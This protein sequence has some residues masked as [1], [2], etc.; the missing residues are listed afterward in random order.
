MTEEKSLLEQFHNACISGDIDVVKSLPLDKAQRNAKASGGLQAIHYASM[1]G[2][3][4]VAQYLIKEGAQ[5]NARDDNGMSPLHHACRN[6][7]IV[8]VR[9][10]M[11]QK[12][13]KNNKNNEGMSPLLCAAAAGHLEIVKLLF[14]EKVFDFIVDNDGNSALHL[15][16]LNRQSALALWLI[17][18]GVDTNVKNNKGLKP[19]EVL[20]EDAFFL[21]PHNAALS[22]EDVMPITKNLGIDDHDDPSGKTNISGETLSNLEVLRHPMDSKND[23]DAIIFEQPVETSKSIGWSTWLETYGYNS[24]ATRELKDIFGKIADEY[25]FFK[26]F[27]VI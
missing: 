24:D 21:I 8:F 17:Q 9:W 2:H 6:G 26:F 5:V 16:Y 1:F 19:H 7:H 20:E 12:I 10:L 27:G 3:L 4:E 14:A 23:Y 22:R 18:Y 25:L 13:F 15:A 11:K